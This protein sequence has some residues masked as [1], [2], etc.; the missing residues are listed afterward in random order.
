MNGRRDEHAVL[1]INPR[2]GGGKAERYHLVAECTKRGIEAV[3]LGQGDDVAAVA[4]AAAARADVIG[5]AGGDGTEASVAAAAAERAIPFVCVPAGTR[6][7]F[8]LDLGV[9]RHDVVGALDAFRDGT[10][11]HVDLGRVNGHTFV[12]NAS[13]GWYGKLVHSPSY[14]DAKW[15]TAFETLPEVLGPRSAPFRLRFRGPDGRDLDEVHI[16][17]VS[18]NP[19]NLDVLPGM[20]TRGDINLGTLGIMAARLRPP[21]PPLPVGTTTTLRHW[22]QWTVA[23]FRV[24]ADSTIELGLDGEARRLDPPLLFESVPNALRVRTHTRPRLPIA[25]PPLPRGPSPLA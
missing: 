12:N 13:M 24:D 22:L 18:N 23:A 21:R 14:R 8:A 1:I 20:A 11:R 6:N 9:D 7:H 3:L 10:E 15:R 17:L 5:A 19:Y 4:A 16:L 25:P 2:S